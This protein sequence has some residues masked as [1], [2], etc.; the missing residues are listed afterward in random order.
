TLSG[1]QLALQVDGVLAVQSDAVPRL[2]MGAAHAVRD[3]FATVI[4]P[5][6]EGAIELRVTADGETYCTVTIP[7]GEA[8]SDPWID[9]LTL[10]PLAEGCQVG[11]DVI[12]TGSVRPGAGLTVTIRF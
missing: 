7:A 1:G 10:P 5:S 12:A 6:T 8:L 11:L 2:N 4:E 9:G 3:V